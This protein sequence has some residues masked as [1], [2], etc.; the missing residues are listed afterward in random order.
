MTFFSVL[1]ILLPRAL[2][3]SG[4]EPLELVLCVNGRLGV[5]KMRLCARPFS[6]GWVRCYLL[7]FSSGARGN[8]EEETNPGLLGRWC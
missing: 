1:Y 6:S 3:F 8:C 5:T 7:A 2:A 4:E